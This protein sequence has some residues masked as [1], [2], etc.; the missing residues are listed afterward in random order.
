MLIIIKQIEDLLIRQSLCI[1]LKID[2]SVARKSVADDVLIKTF[3]PQERDIRMNPTADYRLLRQSNR[4]SEVLQKGLL[5]KSVE[6]KEFQ[7]I[8]VA[9]TPRTLSVWLLLAC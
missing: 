2:K 6:V 1:L 9:L 8:A 4:T 7:V 5:S 3:L